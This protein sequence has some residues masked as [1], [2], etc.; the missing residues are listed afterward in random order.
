M[1]AP[2]GGAG[3]DGVSGEIG[4]ALG[5]GAAFFPSVLEEPVLWR[6][7]I[8]IIPWSES[9]GRGRGVFVGDMFEGAEGDEADFLAKS[10]G[11]E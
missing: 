11:V 7:V 1:G 3:G 10:G 6:N 9:F 5:A 2:A 4:F 8:N